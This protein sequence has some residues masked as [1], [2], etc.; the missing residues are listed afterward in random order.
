MVSADADKIKSVWDFRTDPTFSAA[1]RAALE[2]AYAAGQ[3]PNA[4]TDAH[5]SELRRFFSERAIL[6]IMGMIALFGF[7][8]RWN[9]TVAT[10]L[11]P[12]PLNFARTTLRPQDWNSGHHAP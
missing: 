10:T 7:L 6:E 2:L 12:V 3:S 9:D 4:A 5:F 11:E 8:N 1:E